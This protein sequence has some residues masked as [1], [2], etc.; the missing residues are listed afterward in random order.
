MLACVVLTARLWLSGYGIS[1]ILPLIYLGLCAQVAYS[2]FYRLTIDEQGLTLAYRRF[3]KPIHYRWDEI[4][5][6]VLQT[7]PLASDVLLH[8][9]L[10]LKNGQM[11]VQDGSPSHQAGRP[12]PCIDL[13]RLLRHRLD[14]SVKTPV[15]P[16]VVPHPPAGQPAS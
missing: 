3:R 11:I 15:T 6:V 9:Q 12:A 16:P 1:L 14:Q 4:D 8:V 13:Y 7:G 2:K 5:R 10:W